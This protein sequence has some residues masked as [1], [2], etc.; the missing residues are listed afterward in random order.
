MLILI[1]LL[2]LSIAPHAADPESSGD[3][4]TASVNISMLNCFPSFIVRW[5]F[6]FV[7]QSTHENHKNLYTTNKGDFTVQSNFG[8]SNSDGSN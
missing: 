6:N 2:K 7:D 5:I 3:S 1:S 4:R 8:A